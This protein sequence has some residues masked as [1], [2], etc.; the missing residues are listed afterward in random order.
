MSFRPSFLTL[1]K[2]FS[3]AVAQAIISFTGFAILVFVISGGIS[4]FNFIPEAYLSLNYLILFFFLRFIFSALIELF[5]RN[6]LIN[7]S[8]N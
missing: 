4:K 3:V 1:F 8:K 5:N 6:I 7:M 2:L